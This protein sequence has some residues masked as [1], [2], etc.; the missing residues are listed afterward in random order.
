MR[1]V[2]LWFV[3]AISVGLF[4]AMLLA[5]RNHRAHNTVRTHAKAAVEYGWATVPWLIVALGAA[6]AVRRLF[7][8]G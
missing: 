1:V 8:A 3:L 2:L 5:L 4:V 6:P 7:A